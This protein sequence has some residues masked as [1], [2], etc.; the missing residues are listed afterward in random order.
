MDSKEQM[1]ETIL[2]LAH[3]ES[4]GSLSKAALE[5]LAAARPSSSARQHGHF[6]VGLFGEKFRRPPTPS[7]NLQRRRHSSEWRTRIR[8]V[9]VCDRRLR[10]RSSLPRIAGDA[11]RHAGTSRW[12]ASLAGRTHR[13][14]GRVD[15]HVNGIK[16]EDSRARHHPLVLSP[17]HGGR[18]QRAQRPWV[19]VVDPGTHPACHR[20]RRNSKVGGSL[21]QFSAKIVY[22]RP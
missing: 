12:T 22:A 19:L 21:G 2:Y 7:P 4:D 20:D 18:R 9:S 10:R 15:T 16:V 13:L 1:M 6:I 17:A 3:T 8:T 5:A 11:G 14:A